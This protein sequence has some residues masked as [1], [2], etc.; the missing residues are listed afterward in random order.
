MGAGTPIPLPSLRRMV[1]GSSPRCCRTGNRASSYELSQRIGIDDL[2]LCRFFNIH[3]LS[4]LDGSPHETPLKSV[5][6]L[7][8][9]H[10]RNP[11]V[12]E[13]QISGSRIALVIQV[14]SFTVART[15]R[16][17]IA[18]DWKTGE[19][20]SDFT[21]WEISFTTS[22][23]VLE[24]SSDDPDIG[25][26]IENITATYFLEDSWL[27]ALSHKSPVA[28]LLVFNTLLP[29][30]DLKSWRILDLPS[31]GRDGYSI[32]TQYEK[33]LT[34]LP[35][36]SVDPDQRF[37]AV[38]SPQGLAFVI[39][40]ELLIKYMHSVRTNSRVPWDEWGE[41]VITVNVHPD[42][43]QL[44]LFDTKVLALRFLPFPE[45][46]GVEMFDLSR[47]SRRDI[48]VQQDNEGAG[49]RCKR[50]LLT[51]K[52]LFRCRPGDGKPFVTRLVGDNLVC[53]FVS[54]LCVQKVHVFNVALY[55]APA[56][57]L[58]RSVFATHPE[59][60]PNVNPG[61]RP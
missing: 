20:V 54:P 51:P 61:E 55:I 32:S 33:P 26:A 38:F 3:L 52:W 1:T 46:L 27:L 31:P 50:I 13:M 8:L 53:V 2:T 23:Q 42:T 29:Q 43:R 44:Q 58:G 12:I 14:S 5:L 41:D 35:E 19:V 56:V 21:S 28:R 4:L 59:I 18:W 17:L 57:T 30:Q 9:G 34:E 40:V 6:A 39:P 11:V 37:F 16:G 49:R 47:S 45:Y 15:R 24:H 36:F 25:D 22:I 10:Y 60:R 7:D 48:Q